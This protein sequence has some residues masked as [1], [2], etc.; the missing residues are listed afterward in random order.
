MMAGKMV[1]GTLSNRYGDRATLVGFTAVSVPAIVALPVVEASGLLVLAV[2][3]A[4]L[5]L[6]YTP[7]ATTY[8]MEFIP[9]EIQGSVFGVIRMI[10]LGVGALAPPVVGFLAD[11]GLFDVAFL[12]LGV[13]AIAAV[14]LSLRLPIDRSP[15]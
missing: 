1:S 6:G 7:V 15:T 13:F 14:G 3:F 8:A 5:I 12:M 11:A 10:F 4:G 9:G 2:W